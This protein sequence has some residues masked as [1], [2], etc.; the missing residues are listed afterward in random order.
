[1]ATANM[2]RLLQDLKVDIP[3]A[4]ATTIQTA[5]YR[6]ADE[7]LDFT[8]VWTEDQTVNL[9]VNQRSYVLA[10]P[11]QGIF[12]RLLVYFDP[13]DAERRWADNVQFF[14]PTGLLVATT[15][16]SA[17]VRSVMMAKK[18]V[19]VDADGNPDMPDNFVQQYREALYDGTR[20]YMHSMPNMPWSDR[21]LALFY[22]Q[23][24]IAGKTVARVDAI[25]ANV[26]GQTNWAFPQIGSRGRQ[27]GV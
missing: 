7:F 14:P 27:R 6:S 15:P 9:V 26:R 5:L 12:C 22:G 19:T 25:K 13:Q 21:A 2:T 11:V 8:N 3:G 4:L 24:F 23:K 10:S 16:S 17:A 20:R 1:M 18:L